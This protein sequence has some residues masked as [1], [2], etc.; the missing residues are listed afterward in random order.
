ME[1]NPEYQRVGVVA[2]A[3]FSVD[4]KLLNS[5]EAF[6]RTEIKGYNERDGL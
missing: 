3:R 1:S 5:S 6:A 4:I 2:P